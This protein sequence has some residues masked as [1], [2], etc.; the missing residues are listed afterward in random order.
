M[1]RSTRA[2]SSSSPRPP[3]PMLWRKMVADTRAL[4][5]EA[6]ALILLVGLGTALF[7]CL[8]QAYENLAAG[9]RWLYDRTHFAHASVV[10]SGGPESLVARARTIPHVTEAIGRPV[11]DGTIIQRDRERK[12]VSGRFI[13]L[14]TKRRL[15]VNDVWVSNGRYIAGPNEAL[16]E[17][18]FATE[19][20]YAIGDRIR[21]SYKSIEREFTIVGFAV[22]PEY[23]CPVPSEHVLFVARGTFGVVFIDEERARLWF[24]TGRQLHD[25]H[26]LTEPGYEDQVLAQLKGLADSYGIVSAF[27]QQ[28]QPSQT[29]LKMDLRVV[30]QLS[31][32]FPTLFLCAAGLLLYGALSRIVRLQV[33]VIGALRACGF[34][35]LQIQVQHTV[36]GLLI[37]VAG[38][39][40]GLVLGHFMAQKLTSLYVQALRYPILVSEPRLGTMAT[41]LLMAAATGLAGAYVPARVASHLRPAEAMRGEVSA[42]ARTAR[43]QRVLRFTQGVG[44]AFR[45][46]L[47]GL[48]RRV[49][50]T[51]MAVLGIAGG[52]VIIVMTFGIRVASEDSRREFL[53]ESRRYELDV[54][55]TRP[56]AESVARATCAIPGVTGVALT[57]SLPVRISTPYGDGRLTLTG[58]ERA[59]RL[60]RVR[61]KGGGFMS[62]YPGMVWLPELLAKRI[63]AEPG[64]L[65]RVQWLGSSR[66]R[67]LET[68]LHV[69]G[70]LDVAIGNTAYA[71]YDD[72]RRSLGDRAYPESTYGA[73]LA[74]DRSLALPVQHRL[75]RS[76]DVACV[77]T[78]DDIRKQLNEQ[79]ALMVLFTLVLLSFGNLLAAIAI[80]SVASITILERTRELATLRSLGLSA[81]MTAL[82]ASME[83]LALALMGL[84]V[85]LPGGAYLN[86]LLIESVRT[87]NISFRPVLPLWVY[88]A[89][90]GMVLLF[91]ALSS[92]VG[93]RRL[94]AMDLA[95]ATKARE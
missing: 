50:R 88:V 55:F 41:G 46:P 9:Y 34:T 63:L 51:V 42:G 49:S 81:R 12:R 85:G 48:V 11:Q 53:T 40:P 92:Y 67:H 28:D 47:R 44:V 64:D 87:E 37:T 95:Q 17:H 27:T 4:A 59:Q 14:P 86:R 16:L 1:R 25:I 82:L 54:S 43:I 2:P 61:A 21:C 20:G 65:V 15:P 5:R 79:F 52:V 72:V 30:G 3:V 76:P 26:C 56:N 6:V 80:H 78:T 18:Q 7:V 91:V 36:Q 31:F 75:V 35:R 45:I 8:H 70:I 69:A 23:I 90:A 58:V 77:F 60:M 38:A 13:G 71:D 93:M 10:L 84:A 19:N 33:A 89:T 32:C 39:L 68:E 62:V 57:V 22:S 74:C 83:L 66:R 29:L 73:L 24:G 94:A